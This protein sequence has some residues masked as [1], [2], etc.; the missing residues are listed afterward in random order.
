MLLLA[1]AG[2]V[3]NTLTI[4]TTEPGADVYLNDQYVGRTPLQRDVTWFGKY[5][6]VVRKDGYQTLKTARWY[7]TPAYLIPPLDLA[8]ALLPFPVISSKEWTFDLAPSP[9]PESDTT[10]LLARGD[11]LKGD[12]KSSEYTRAPATAPT[13]RK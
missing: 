9:A 6:V 10:A 13:T 4:N 12:L 5:D 7:S 8:A 3:E 1:S 11:E 2:C